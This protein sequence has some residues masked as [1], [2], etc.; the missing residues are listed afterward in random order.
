MPPNWV[1]LTDLCMLR[2]RPRR[3]GSVRGRRCRGGKHASARAWS[4]SWRLTRR[5]KTAL[6]RWSGATSRQRRP[7]RSYPLCSAPHPPS[8]V[9]KPTPKPAP[10]PKPGPEPALEPALEPEPEPEPAPA[11][12]HT[13][14]QVG[15][16][17]H[18]DS[19]GGSQGSPRR[20]RG[21]TAAG[22][23]RRLASR[24]HPMAPHQASLRAQDTPTHPGA[25]PGMLTEAPQGPPCRPS[26]AISRL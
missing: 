3:C 25:P 21:G 18:A 20:S 9:P 1:L 14:A 2:D 7:S 19:A 24:S 13:P 11:Y 15:S 23:E 8:P 6:R 17:A 26:Q 10:K 22:L 4:R 16:P 5:A 12:Q